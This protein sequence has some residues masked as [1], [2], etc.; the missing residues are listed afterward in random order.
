MYTSLARRHPLSCARPA[1]LAALVALAGSA[2][3][4]DAWVQTRS[5]H[6]TV[7][8]NASQK[9]AESVALQFERVRAM[10]QKQW[11]WARV[12]AA[13]PT[14]IFAVKDEKTMRS[15]L[16]AFWARRDTSRPAGLYFTSPDRH[17]LIVRTDLRDDENPYALLYHE[18]THRLLALNFP[19]LPLW[20]NEGLAEFYGSSVIE[21]E[22]LTQGKPSP[23]TIFLLR[24]ATLLPLSTLFDVDQTSSH[25]NE[26]TRATIFYAQSW[27]LVH[28]LLLG[29]RKARAPQVN[30]FVRRLRR[31]VPESE[32]RTALGDLKE[33]ER[34]LS[35]Y[36][37]RFLFSYGK[38]ND[39][40]G[41]TDRSMSSR[42]LSRAE[43]A[44]ARGDFLARTGQAADAGPLLEDAIKLDP[45]MP[46]PYE[47]Q[48]ALSLGR[49]RPD[50]ARANAQKAIVRSTT[51][52]F[53]WYLAGV[54]SATDAKLAAEAE[55]ALRRSLE[56][57]PDFPGTVIALAAVL[58]EDEAHREESARLALRVPELV[59][60]NFLLHLTAAATLV[61]V[62]RTEEARAIATRVESLAPAGSLKEAAKKLLAQ[63]LPKDPAKRLA[64]HL[65]E[66]EGGNASECREAGDLYRDGEGM[67]RDYPRAAELYRRAC[68]GGHARG[69][70]W[71]AEFY[72]EGRG[73]AK[74]ETRAATLYE[75]ACNGAFMWACAH[76][77][78]AYLE[79]AGVPKDLAKSEPYLVEGCDN[80]E[81]WV[82]SRL[83]WLLL[84]GRGL[85]A[86]LPRAAKLYEKGC[87][88]DYG[89]G[90]ACAGL[91]WMYLEGKGVA[92][93]DARATE[94]Y[95]KACEKGNLGSC[96]TA[97]YR[98]EKGTGLSADTAAAALLY[99]KGCDGNDGRSCA[100]LALLYG[101]G[102]GVSADPPRSLEL[103]R[104]AC[105]HGDGMGCSSVADAYRMGAVVEIDL[106]RA[107][108]YHEKACAAKNSSD[109]VGLARALLEGKGAPRNAARAATLLKQG[110]DGGDGASCAGLAYC[111]GRGEGTPLDFDK[112]AELAKKACAAGYTQSCSLSNMTPEMA[113]QT[114][115]ASEKTCNEGAAADCGHAGV[116]LVHQGSHDAAVPLFNRGCDAGD[117]ASC[118]QLATAYLL[119]RGVPRDA[120][121][122]R[123]LYKKACDAGERSAC[124][125]LRLAK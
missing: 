37:H 3:A 19:W 120:D 93:N 108:E 1:A 33:L 74:D 83:A 10:F 64:F 29:D 96:A 122:A 52:Y 92:Q 97:G 31:G 47:T 104:K 84:G 54:L 62:D 112:A 69:C 40:L 24:S 49:Q 79:G 60:T 70:A 42:P 5:A 121:R 107:F 38:A 80:G 13:E 51:N 56:L 35:S 98:L 71:L 75:R 102:R 45:S 20:L 81:E 91:A 15:L 110:C 109:C 23:E 18:Y 7:V 65:K 95:R 87:A 57:N 58:A 113:K 76:L 78:L 72:Q 90:H 101:F 55:K 6:F 66:C 125:A 27:A 14:V 8:S 77:G 100:Y 116:V 30:E 63:A 25:Y 9:T 119:G 59:P 44:A 4:D 68:D 88:D 32:A 106:K 50:E 114:V 123:V 36:V 26:Q 94:L 48:A 82:C 118:A 43:E 16:P 46:E 39:F 89:N 53:T 41:A 2:H 117:R 73:V 85:P 124:E 12:D 86:D 61:K 28:Y 103:F 11:P 21:G 115:A 99:Q 111:Y 22:D 34:A 17:T 105:D 67:A